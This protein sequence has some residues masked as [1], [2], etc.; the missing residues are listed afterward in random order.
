MKKGQITVRG[1]GVLDGYLSKHFGT[2]QNE[3]SAFGK[4]ALWHVYHLPTGFIL[5]DATGFKNKRDAQA[6]VAAVEKIEADWSH[7]VPANIFA[8]FPGG[9]EA[10]RRAVIHVHECIASSKNKS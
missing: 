6:M 8:S 4:G 1:V 3:D 9:K 5:A 2:A 10:L 7:D